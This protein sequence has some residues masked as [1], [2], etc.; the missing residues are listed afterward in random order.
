MK[1]TLD[2]TDKFL[3]KTR[4]YVSHLSRWDRW[5]RIIA[6]NTS[7]AIVPLMR[8]SVFSFDI[9]AGSRRNIWTWIY[10][11]SCTE[12][13]NSS[14]S[15]LLEHKWFFWILLCLWTHCTLLK[16]KRWKVWKYVK[17]LPYKLSLHFLNIEV[18]I[19]FHCPNFVITIDPQFYFSSQCLYTDKKENK[20][21]PHM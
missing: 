10:A 15:R 3:T 16:T 1:N 20:N 18:C 19:R 13:Q 21:F 8:F 7:H 17:Q 9:P 6:I 2:Y 5:D 14:C 11:Q 12:F 4:S